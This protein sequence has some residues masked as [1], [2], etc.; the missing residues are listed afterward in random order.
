MALGDDRRASGRQMEQARRQRGVEMETQRRAIGANMEA[1]R[2]G[3]AVVEDIQRIQSP[4]TTR[5]T[6]PPVSSA[7]GI[8]AARGRAYYPAGQKRGGG[9]GIASP[10][11]EVPDSRVYS[12]DA[13]WVETIDGAGL[14][15]VRVVQKMTFTDADDNPVEFNLDA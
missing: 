10:L 13:T 9:S 7:G 5:R 6:L 12:E 4:P 14:L 1:A 11:T 3:E 15:K 2:R 8:P